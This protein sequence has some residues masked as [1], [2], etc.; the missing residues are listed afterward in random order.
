MKSLSFSHLPESKSPEELFSFI[1]AIKSRDMRT[2][3]QW[4]IQTLTKIFQEGRVWIRIL[5]GLAIILLADNEGIFRLSYYS[6]D[7][8]EI[9]KINESLPIGMSPIMC[10]LVGKEPAVKEHAEELASFFPLYAQYRRMICTDLIPTQNID[11]SEVGLALLG[12]ENEL[13]EM[14]HNEFDVLTARMPTLNLIRQRIENEDVFLVRKDN[15]IA[16]FINFDSKRQK[17]ALLDYV[18]V[19]PE[20][21]N[22]HIARKIWNYKLKEHN[23]SK[24]YYLWVNMKRQAA[25]RFHES[26]K[27]RFDGLIDNI[28]KIR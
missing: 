12:D 23:E 6:G 22:Q 1:R 3:S 13:L 17:A 7:A 21:R 20:Y 11:I 15:R 5:D 4:T 18:L 14:L 8:R 28:Y 26:N 19:R 25:I 24:Y 16:G 9:A 27:F 10:D 2:N